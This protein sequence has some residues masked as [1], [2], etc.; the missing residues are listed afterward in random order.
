MQAVDA[1]IVGRFLA[2]LADRGIDLLLRLF[3]HLLDAC[4]M[5]A[6]VGDKSGKGNPR[7][8]ATYGIKTG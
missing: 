4:R 1:Q 8:L 6:A 2:L 3:D 5:D 7:H